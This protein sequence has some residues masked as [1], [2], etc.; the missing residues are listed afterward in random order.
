MQK[1]RASQ[2]NGKLLPRP[3]GRFS[4]P[5]GR[6]IVGPSS[7]MP[8]EGLN[9]LMRRLHK[10]RMMDRTLDKEMLNLRRTDLMLSQLGL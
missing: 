10:L 8:D 2:S 9:A 4:I 1:Y 7:G 5:K 6:G 3:N